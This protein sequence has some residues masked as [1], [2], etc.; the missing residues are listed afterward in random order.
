MSLLH[1]TSSELDDVLLKPNF[2]ATFFDVIP[3]VVTTVSSE[4]P[5]DFTLGIK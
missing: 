5:P 1:I 2:C 3:F 4:A